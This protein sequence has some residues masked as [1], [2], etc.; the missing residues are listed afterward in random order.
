MIFCVISQR[1]T[2]ILQPR[3]PNTPQLRN[4]N[5]IAIRD[6]RIISATFFINSG[7]L[8]SGE[9][10][11]NCRS[12]AASAKPRPARGLSRVSS[13][14]T[15]LV[16]NWKGKWACDL[17]DCGVRRTWRVRRMKQVG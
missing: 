9:K 17:R 12:P 5:D 1:A 15:G 6:P 10:P 14:K 16:G 3:E 8:S 4:T 7:V 11:E 2:E 13:L